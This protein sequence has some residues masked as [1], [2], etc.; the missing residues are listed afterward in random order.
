[1]ATA[2]VDPAMQT[3]QEAI[4]AAFARIA[5]LETEVSSQMR[6]AEAAESQ[7]IKMRA[8]LYQAREALTATSAA[9]QQHRAQTRAQHEI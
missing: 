9:E 1:M 8:A 5:A 3:L 2:A 6:R 4:A 7:V